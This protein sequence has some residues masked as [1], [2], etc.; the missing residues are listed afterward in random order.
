[1]AKRRW[2]AP[3]GNG[4]RKLFQVKFKSGQGQ[5]VPAETAEEARAMMVAHYGEDY[6]IESVEELGAKDE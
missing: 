2:N 3:S 1:M 4:D 5:Q 6:E